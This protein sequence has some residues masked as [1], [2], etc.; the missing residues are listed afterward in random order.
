MFD[1]DSMV[2]D[3][4]LSVAHSH[5]LVRYLDGHLVAGGFL[6]AVLKNDL[7]GAFQ[8][9]DAEGRDSIWGLL[10]WL[11]KYAP[12]SAWGSPE[13]VDAWIQQAPQ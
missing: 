7:L 4:G 9:A 12:S 11:S 6:M 8:M 3:W 1:Q 2:S 13:K 10:V 5:G